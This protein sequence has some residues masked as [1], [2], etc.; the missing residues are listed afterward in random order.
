MTTERRTV[1]LAPK[2]APTLNAIK[3]VAHGFFGR[4][5]GVSS[6]LYGSLNCGLGS[7]DERDCVYENRERVAAHLGTTGSQLLTCY[8][9][10]S[11][12][13]VIVERPWP[14]D[15]QP[16][17]DA[18]ATR[19]KGLA[20]GALAADCAPVLFA[21]SRAGVIAAA[22]AGWKGA[23]SGILES[24]LAAMEQLGSH[25]SDIRAVVGP[26]IGPAA[27]EVGPEFEAALVAVNQDY[28]DYFRRQG[29]TG[30]A[31]F[32]LP[33]FVGDRLRAAG[34]GSVESAWQCTYTEKETY[35]SFRR[36]THLREN[37]Y[38]RQISAI[39]LTGD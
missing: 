6:G 26:C 36:T 11:A 38:G 37:D 29:A 1:V 8:Q 7:A 14:S 10:H 35:F 25:R 24:T 23:L 31:H 16:R 17:A 15:Q 27:Y 28:A 3:G 13:A 4:V 9:V 20:L 30:R 5:G 22:H 18:L 2:T 12:E 39:M 32:D 34:A 33:Q 21:D 19:A